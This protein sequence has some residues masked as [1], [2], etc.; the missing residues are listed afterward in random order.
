MCVCR[1]LFVLW[2]FSLLS[3][4]GFGYNDEDYSDFSYNDIT[5]G[6]EPESESESTL[7]FTFTVMETDH[8]RLFSE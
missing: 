1:A 3:R 8:F 7:C 5:D 6:D 4:N 2:I